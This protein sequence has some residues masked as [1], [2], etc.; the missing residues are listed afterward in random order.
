MSRTFEPVWFEPAGSPKLVQP[1][2]AAVPV[3]TR[4]K[5]AAVRSYEVCYFADLQFGYAK[6]FQICENYLPEASGAR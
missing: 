1:T 4:Q 2:K 3:P 5:R 6:Y